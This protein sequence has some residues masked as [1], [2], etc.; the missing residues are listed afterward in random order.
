M[1]NNVHKGLM[2]KKL[3]MHYELQFLSLEPN[4]PSTLNPLLTLLTIN[5]HDYPIAC[6]DHVINNIINH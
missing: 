4:Y 5:Y 2:V 3:L 6:M 1:V